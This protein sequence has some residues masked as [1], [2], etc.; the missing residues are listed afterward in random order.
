[1]LHTFILNLLKNICSNLVMCRALLAVQETVVSKKDTVPAR[2]INQIIPQ[3]AECNCHECHIG[4]SKGNRTRLAS[5]S[6][7]SA[8][9]SLGGLAETPPRVLISGQRGARWCRSTAYTGTASVQRFHP[10]R[11]TRRWSWVWRQCLDAPG[12]GE[13]SC[14]GPGAGGRL[15]RAGE[16]RGWCGL[17]WN[18]RAGPDHREAGGRGKEC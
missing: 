18:W 3:V 10:A 12:R 5:E 11:K 2:R 13:S 7:T 4:A 6:Q 17:R 9:E 16:G 14:K 8:L 15:K 1:M